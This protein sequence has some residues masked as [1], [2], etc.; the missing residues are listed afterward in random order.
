MT[1]EWFVS[2]IVEIVLTAFCGGLVVYVK[3]LHKHYIAM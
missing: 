3:S 1:L 2:H